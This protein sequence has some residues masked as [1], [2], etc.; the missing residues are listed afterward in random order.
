[1]NRNFTEIELKMARLHVR[2]FLHSS[3]IKEMQIKNI[4]NVDGI[5]GSQD[6]E[7]GFFTCYRWKHKLLQQP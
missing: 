1:M 7:S 3:M 6:A 2:K 5:P 4:K